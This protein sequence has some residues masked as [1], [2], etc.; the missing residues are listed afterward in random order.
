MGRTP[1]RDRER[2]RQVMKDA[3]DCARDASYEER[4]RYGVTIPRD[5]QLGVG[6]LLLIAEQQAEMLEIMREG[7]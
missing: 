2:Q 1:E 6:L 4:S 5:Q 7:N 3:F